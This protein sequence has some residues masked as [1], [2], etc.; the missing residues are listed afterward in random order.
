MLKYESVALEFPTCLAQAPSRVFFVNAYLPFSRAALHVC[1][2][3]SYKPSVRALQYC[4]SRNDVLVT[5]L[6]FHHCILSLR[7]SG[8][9]QVCRSSRERGSESVGPRASYERFMP[10]LLWS[11]PLGDNAVWLGDCVEMMLNLECNLRVSSSSRCTQHLERPESR[12]K[13]VTQGR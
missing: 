12:I 5:V 11:L 3:S 4:A 13:P 8:S 2:T 1:R 10:E 6:F 9:L 7:V